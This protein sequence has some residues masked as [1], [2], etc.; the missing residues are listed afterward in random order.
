MGRFRDRHTHD[1]AAE[2]NFQVPAQGQDPASANGRL[3]EHRLREAV[4]DG[5][6]HLNYQ[7]VVSIADGRPVALE[8]LLRWKSQTRP[9][10]PGTFIPVLEATGLIRDIGPWI[11]S[12]ACR[13]ARSWLENVPDL[14]LAVNVSPLQLVPG[15]AESVLDILKITGVAPE[16]LCLEL[17]RPA[18]I[19]DPV[20]AWSELR[21][22]KNLGVRLSVDDFGALGS[23]IADLRRF[24][25]DTVKID[26]SLVSGLVH[27]PDDDAIVGALIALARALRMQTIAEGVETAAQYQRLHELGCDFAQG[28]HLIPPLAPEAVETF[29]QEAPTVLKLP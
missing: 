2:N 24:C 25:V 1:Q 29:L 19:A 4:A 15:F 17:V 16:R 10:T 9:V 26:Q 22:V 28:F 8:A 21:G 11:L 7:P 6:F 27:N 18:S 14:V 12:E 3:L 20:V 13:E 23:S 5:K